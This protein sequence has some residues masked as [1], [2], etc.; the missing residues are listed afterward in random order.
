M[1]TQ[2]N[3]SPHSF[4]PVHWQI[5]ESWLDQLIC[6][7]EHCLNPVVKQMVCVPW[8]RHR[9]VGF[10][11]HF[12]PVVTLL[13]SVAVKSKV[14][15]KLQLNCVSITCLKT[16]DVGIFVLPLNSPTV[17]LGLFC[18]LGVTF[19]GL[20]FAFLKWSVFFWM[21]FFTPFLL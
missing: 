20:L 7:T 2:Y 5:Y 15:C 1:E 19:W 4:L 21:Y 6:D 18:G 12:H 3:A 16:T 8:T 11:L 17:C 10:V 9:K 13:L 14:S